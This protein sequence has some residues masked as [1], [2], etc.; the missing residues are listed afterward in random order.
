[1]PLLIGDQFLTCVAKRDEFLDG[2]LRANKGDEAD[3]NMM[4]RYMILGE[5]FKDLPVMLAKFQE[6]VVR[7]NGLELEGSA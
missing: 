3:L 7:L 5:H 1:M 2:W 6:E 4:A